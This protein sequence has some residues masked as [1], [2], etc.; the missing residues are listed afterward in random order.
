MTL[1]EA[2]AKKGVEQQVAAREIGVSPFQMCRWVGGKL[3]DLEHRRKL[4][5]YFGE[6]YC[7]KCIDRI[8]NLKTKPCVC[9]E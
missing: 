6:V 1:R 9:E 8:Q 5:E 2:I 7:E 3:P 4:N